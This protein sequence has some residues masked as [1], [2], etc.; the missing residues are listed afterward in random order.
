MTPCSCRS[1]SSRLWDGPGL[2]LRRSLPT[3]GY[4][5]YTFH[6]AG[7]LV[8]AEPPLGVRLGGPGASSAPAWPW[9]RSSVAGCAAAAGRRGPRCLVGGGTVPLLGFLRR[10]C[11]CG[12]EPCSWDP[13]TTSRW[14]RCWRSRLASRWMTSGAGG[15][16]GAAVAVL[17]AGAPTLAVVVPRLVEQHE[18]SE[19]RSEVA[20]VLA[21]RSSSKGRPSCSCLP[22]YGPFLQNPLS[23]LRNQPGL[24]GP[25]AVRGRPGRRRST[26]A[27]RRR[28]LSRRAYRSLRSPTAGT[29]SPALILRR[30]WRRCC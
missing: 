28:T 7:L 4:V 13:S 1:R 25:G 14:W 3:D 18:R 20:E 11:S 16:R 6:R 2:G 21:R 29:T 19:P 17:G 12:T 9:R 5:D 15:P 10:P 23:F 22:P 26:A 30:A 27:C 24:D 8:R